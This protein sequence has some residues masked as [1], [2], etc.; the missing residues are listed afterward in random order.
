MEEKTRHWLEHLEQRINEVEELH[1]KSSVTEEQG[2]FFDYI[3][4][5]ISRR[6]DELERNHLNNYRLIVDL[7]S[8]RKVMKQDVLQYKKKIQQIEQLLINNGLIHLLTK[9]K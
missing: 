3:Y 2:K 6:L 1:G 5:S 9:E 4:P 8:E 7:K